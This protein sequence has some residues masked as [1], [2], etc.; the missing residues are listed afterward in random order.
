MKKNFFA[1]FIYISIILAAVVGISVDTIH[2]EKYY[3]NLKKTGEA[4][5][6]KN[7]NDLEVYHIMNQED[8]TQKVVKNLEG[9]ELSEKA[10]DW[11]RSEENGVFY[12]KYE[13]GE[14]FEESWSG[15]LALLFLIIIGVTIL[16]YRNFILCKRAERILKMLAEKEEEVE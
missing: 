4:L 10:K 7:G 11:C 2:T 1:H 9:Y 13:R 14:N 15:P 6:I 3:D 8:G 12:S 16:L 5:I